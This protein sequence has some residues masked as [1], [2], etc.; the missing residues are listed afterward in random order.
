M[1]LAD[2]DV[3]LA[4]TFMEVFGVLPDKEARPSAAA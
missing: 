2:L 4:E 3:A 1:T